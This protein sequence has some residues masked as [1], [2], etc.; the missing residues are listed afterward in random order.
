MKLKIIPT[1]NP[2]GETIYKVFDTE[3]SLFILVDG[4]NTEKSKELALKIKLLPELIC[5]SELLLNR[6]NVCLDDLN[7]SGDRSFDA[8]YEIENLQSILNNFKREV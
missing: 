7:Q 6:L 4:V 1:K 3:S 2:L 5:N 8:D